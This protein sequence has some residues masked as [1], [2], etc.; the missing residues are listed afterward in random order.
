MTT[1]QAA[2]IIRMLLGYLKGEIEPPKQETI[3]EAKAFEQQGYECLEMAIKALEQEP[4]EDWYDVPSNEMTL[5]QAR[6][7]VKDLRKKLAEY[8]EQQPCED[9]V[10]RQD[11]LNCVT[12]NEVRY[13]MVEDINALPSV[14][15]KEKWISVNERLP[16]DYQRV[17]VTV[18]RYNGD[19]VVRVAEYYSRSNGKGIFQ[20][21]ENDEQ[22]EVGEKGLLAWMPLPEPY[23]EVSE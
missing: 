13:R 8:L 11:A 7:A 6:Q 23:K 5:E 16:E 12:F 20:I 4:C 19:R 10:N 18:V 21:K 1:K 14:T 22:W 17:L 2:D 9:A 15:P 3:E